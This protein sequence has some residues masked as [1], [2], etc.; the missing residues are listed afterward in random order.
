MGNSTR[1]L[2]IIDMTLSG[3]RCRRYGILTIDVTAEFC[4]WTDQRPKRIFN[5][6]RRIGRNSRSPKYHFGRQLFQL[7][8]G[9]LNG[10]NRLAICELWQSE[11]R[12]DAKITFLADHTF[13]YKTGSWQ[14]FTMTSL[15]T[16]HMKNVAN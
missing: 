3:K 2:T 5:F 16:L 1:F 10:S 6:Q 14:N 9:P 8:D 11:T 4:S 12:P 7:S 13:L 15:E